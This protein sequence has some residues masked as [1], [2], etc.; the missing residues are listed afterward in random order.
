MIEFVEYSTF[1]VSS[2][3][4]LISSCLLTLI[5]LFSGWKILVNPQAKSQV[6]T[7]NN[8]NEI[9]SKPKSFLNK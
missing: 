8:Q 4:K 9:S 7:I 1:S 2:S 5:W 3:P 6:P